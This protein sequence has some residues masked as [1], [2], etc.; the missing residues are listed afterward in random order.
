MARDRSLVRASDLGA[1]A[2]CHRAWWLANVRKVAH[3]QPELLARGTALHVRH[4]K[5]VGRSVALQRAG[6]LVLLLALFLTSIAV[7]LKYFS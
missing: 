6:L 4:G 5:S 3:E 1:W 7:A 2:Y